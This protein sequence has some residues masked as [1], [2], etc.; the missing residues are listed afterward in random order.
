M[1]EENLRKLCAEKAMGYIKNNTVIGLGAGRNIACLI[2]LISDEVKKNN[3]KIKIVSPSDNTKKLC[4]KYGLEVLPTYFSDEVEI[5]FDGCGEVDENLYASKGG[6]G[7]FTKE[8][9]IGAMA[10]EYVLL[11]DEQKYTKELTCKYP[12]S[13]EI[14]KDSMGY[15]SKSVKKLGGTPIVRIANNKDGYLITDDG[16]FILDVKFEVMNDIKQL[17]DK[18]SCIVGVVETS[19][20]TN[21]VTKL[22]IAK[23]SGIS[24]IS[25]S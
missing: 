7:V 12:I 14:V 20:F 15:V 11:I 18:L 9:I 23:E 21:E 4:I 22:L 16:N 5:S 17:N 10:K 1:T 13:L 25:K 24:V 19:L 6:G 2:E 3:L 8:K